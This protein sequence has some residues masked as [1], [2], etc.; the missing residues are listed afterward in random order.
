[1]IINSRV[2][3]K[4]EVIMLLVAQ[5]VQLHGIPG[6]QNTDTPQL[7]ELDE[8]VDIV[9]VAVKLSWINSTDYPGADLKV[10]TENAS[11]RFFLRDPAQKGRAG[12]VP[13]WVSQIPSRPYINSTELVNDS[14]FQKSD[15]TILP[16]TIPLRFD[17]TANQGFTEKQMFVIQCATNFYFNHSPD[18]EQADSD[19]WESTR[20]S[21]VFPTIDLNWE[22]IFVAP[23]EQQKQL[24]S[25]I[26]AAMIAGSVC[27]MDIAAFV[28]KEQQSSFENP[29]S[30][31]VV[32]TKNVPAYLSD[33]T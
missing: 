2:A 3:D 10:W 32:G 27:P 5:T 19:L 4:H 11:V 7:W 12:A 31:D 24:A 21:F 1:M 23:S 30:E 25:H 20:N 6:I 13:V 28:L 18:S 8:A 16:T 33:E 22:D 26:E 15:S 9:H 14:N 17:L 29:K